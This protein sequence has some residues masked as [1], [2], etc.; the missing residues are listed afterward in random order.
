MTTATEILPE[1]D[2]DLSE[3]DGHAHYARIDEIVAGGPLIALCGKKYIPT[4]IGPEV[5]NLPLCAACDQLMAMIKSMEEID[6][7]G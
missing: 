2:K 7:A 5:C 3:F 4:V 1:I 6:A